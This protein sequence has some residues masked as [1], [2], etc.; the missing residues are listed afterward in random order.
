VEN[1]YR[2][3]KSRRL[4]RDSEFQRVRA[5]GQSLRSDLLTLAFVLECGSAAPRA[6]V[7]T[8]KRLGNAATRNRVRRRLREIFRK[9][10]HGI[11]AGVW[12]VTIAS[13]RAVHV[14][15]AVLED[16]WLRLVRR[17]SILAP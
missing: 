3:P 5:E 6:G 11:A 7:I 2:L 1:R 4:T 13:P 9:H 12:L 17:A 15:F 14:S 16:E 8:S 10:Q